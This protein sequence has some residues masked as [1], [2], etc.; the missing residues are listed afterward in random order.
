MGLLYLS[1]S[2]FFQKV[3]TKKETE[4]S[5]GYE[6]SREHQELREKKEVVASTALFLAYSIKLFILQ[7]FLPVFH[8]IFILPP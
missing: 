5:H 2:G 4:T 7:L 1:A 6:P 8:P 3:Y